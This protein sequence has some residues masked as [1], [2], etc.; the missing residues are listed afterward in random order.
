MKLARMDIKGPEEYI[1]KLSKLGNASTNIC[2]RAVKAGANPVAD[3]MR[4]SLQSLPEDTFRRL[5]N[6]EKFSGVP[7]AQ[8]K[9]LLDS[10]GITPADVDRNGVINTK[11]GFHGYGSHGTKKYPNGLPNKLLARAIE[12]GSS[13]RKKTPFVRKAVS[14]TKNQALEEIRVSID[15]DISKFDL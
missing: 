7:E 13:V 5:D 11:V 6:D 1:S 2:K 4:K 14:K 8:K 9:D 10:L 12:S 15:N 3:E